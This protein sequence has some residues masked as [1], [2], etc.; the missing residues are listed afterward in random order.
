MKTKMNRD[1]QFCVTLA[2][3]HDEAQADFNLREFVALVTTK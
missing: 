3:P 2:R 1:L